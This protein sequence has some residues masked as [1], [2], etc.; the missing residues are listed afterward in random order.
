[1]SEEDSVLAKVAPVKG[2]AADEEEDDAADGDDGQE[3]GPRLE[4]DG[5]AEDDGRRAT[6]FRG[7]REKTDIERWWCG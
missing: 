2:D 1:M 7:T 3:Y 5:W 4:R 6:G